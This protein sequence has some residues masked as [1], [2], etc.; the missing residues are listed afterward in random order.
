[1]PDLKRGYN[2]CDQDMYDICP[3]CSIGIY[4]A[5]ADKASD[6][7]ISPSKVPDA[8]SPSKVP[9]ADK[10]PDKVPDADKSPD[11]VPDAEKSPDKV[12]DAEKK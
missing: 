2:R 11:K 6:A 5:N 12:P 1:M 8:E 4:P 3:D 7:D 10:S 9:D